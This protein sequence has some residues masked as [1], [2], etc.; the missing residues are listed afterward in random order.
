MS[1]GRKRVPTRLHILR[2]NPSKLK[3][4]KGELQPAP[5]STLEPPGHLREHARQVWFRVAPEFQAQGILTVNDLLAF[6]NLCIAWGDLIEAERDIAAN[7]HVYWAETKNGRIRMRNPYC[8]I[9]RHAQQQCDK[10][11]AQFGIGASYRAKLG[12]VAQ[13]KEDELTK[14]RKSKG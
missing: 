5:I 4:P 2:G 10:W 14:W 3:L 13:P 12:I 1:K 7:G 11:A 8:A 6:E 9:K